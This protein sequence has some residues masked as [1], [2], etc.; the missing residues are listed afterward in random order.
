MIRPDRVKIEMFGGVGFRQTTLAD[1]PVIDALNS[2]SKSGLYFQDGASFITIQNIYD[3]QQDKD[4]SDIDFNT[5]LKN[6]QESCILEVC[7]KINKR[8]SDFIQTNNVYPYEK[9]FKDT[10][11]PAGKFVGFEITPL[12]K[13]G[14]IGK[15]NWIELAFDSDVSMNVYL[16]NSNLPNTPI[17]TQAVSTIANESTVISLDDWEIGDNK[18]YKGG[19]FYFGY[20]ENDLAG[21]KAYKKDYESANNFVNTRCHYITPISINHNTLTLDITTTIEVSDTYG[22]N[23][24]IDVYEDYTEIF[25]RNKSLIYQAV[26]YQMA[27]KVLNLIRVSVRSNNIQRLNKDYL[28]NI[29]F[30]LY[31]NPELQIFGIDGKLKR[32]ISDARKMFFYKPMISRRTLS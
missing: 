4:I 13:S 15:I 26:Q 29:S 7:Q 31:G 28:S 6:L 18:D 1:Y 5:Y 20:F 14:I 17:K 10:I 25:I 12:K 23:F 27:E 32:I 22:L 21:S 19:K 30:E 16:Y 24:G 2:L 8:E 11:E 3:C 9:S